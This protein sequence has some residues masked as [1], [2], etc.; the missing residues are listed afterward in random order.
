MEQCAVH[1]SA[2]V[3]A[4]CS[5]QKSGS[6]RVEKRD[7]RASWEIQSPFAQRAAARAST[8]SDTLSDCSTYSVTGA[9]ALRHEQRGQGYA[10]E[11]ERAQAQ[12]TLTS[13]RQLTLP[14]NSLPSFRLLHTIEHRARCSPPPLS[15]STPPTASPPQPSPHQRDPHLPLSSNHR[16][17]AAAATTLP[18]PR[19]VTPLRGRSHTAQGAAPAEVVAQPRTPDSRPVAGLQ[20]LRPPT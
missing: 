11:V 8:D 15:P 9:D 6:D 18:T 1:S 17:A 20:A 10:T 12:R 16:A 13:D 7:D 5:C 4:V 19:S 2:S 3:C 14:R